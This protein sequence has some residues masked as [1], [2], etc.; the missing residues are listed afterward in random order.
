MKPYK[1][2]PGEWFVDVRAGR[3]KRRQLVY[4]GTR[5]EAE[6]ME[7]ALRAEMGRPAFRKDTI[8]GMAE[9]FLQHVRLHSSDKTYKDKKRMLFSSLLGYF[10][11]MFPDLI[12]RSTIDAFQKKRKA[13]INAP[14]PEDKQRRYNRGGNASINKEVLCLAA[15]IGWAQ[16]HGLCNN[17]ICEYKPLPYH[18]PKPVILSPE[19]ALS[20]IDHA[21]PFWKCVFL[22]L[23]QAGMRLNEVLSLTSDR[24]HLD[25]IRKGKKIISYGAIIA[26]GKGDKERVIPVTERLYKALK[27]YLPSLETELLF[28]NPKTKEQ[29]TDIRKALERARVAAGIEKRVYPH[30]MR[31][32]FATHLIEGGGD[33]R[34]VQELLGHEEVTT[35]QFYT[36]VA[37][38]HLVN[39]INK[40][41]RHTADKSS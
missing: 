38:G 4:K 15:L 16:E 26:K 24:V 28:P 14:I 8:N 18:R 12:T 7:R 29:Y 3:E 9:D 39:T 27:E 25:I 5:E 36:H 34:G 19:E 37:F 32:S 35:T 11:N 33:L 31:H 21:E 41:E 2:R 30:L 1:E 10:G 6:I 17:R 40:L 22:C 23:Y 20:M 13:E